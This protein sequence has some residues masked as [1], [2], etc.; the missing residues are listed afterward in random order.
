MSYPCHWTRYSN[1]LQMIL[2]LRISKTSNSSCPSISIGGGGTWDLHGMDDSLYGSSKET[3]NIGWI[4]IEG[5]NSKWN[6]TSLICLITKKGPR[7]RKSSLLHGRLVLRLRRSSHTLSPMLI[8]GCVFRDLSILSFYR[9]WASRSLSFISV[10]ISNN[11]IVRFP[12]AGFSTLLK[13]NW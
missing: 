11:R 1:F 3:W 12:A 7:R 4:F 9:S 13:S 6:A 2:E 8:T 10:W 5:S